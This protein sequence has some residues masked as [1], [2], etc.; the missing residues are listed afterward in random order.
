MLVLFSKFFK[1]LSVVVLIYIQYQNVY[2]LSNR[3]VFK[4]IKAVATSILN[5]HSLLLN[6]EKIWKRMVALAYSYIGSFFLK[7][8]NRNGSMAHYNAI[9]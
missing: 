1:Q 9:L 4:K 7:D 8:E 2:K 5:R 3:K 6:I